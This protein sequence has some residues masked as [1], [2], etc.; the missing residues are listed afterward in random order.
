MTEG[1]PA[2]QRTLALGRRLLVPLSLPWVVM[3]LVVSKPL[4]DAVGERSRDVTVDLGTLWA[5]SM[6]L[7]GVY[8]AFKQR[9]LSWA[10]IFLI[11]SIIG[12]GLGAFVA[13]M[14][15]REHVN[16]IVVEGVRLVAGLVPAAILMGVS[17]SGRS[18]R[19]K[20]LL[21][22]F[23]LGV[24]VH[25]V[26]AVLQYVGYIPTT[27]FQV[28]QPRPSGLYFH[29]VSLGILVNVSLLLVVLA[30]FRGWMRL[31]KAL[32][33]SSVLLAVGVLSTHRAS[34]VVAVIIMFGWLAIRLI[35]EARTLRINLWWV[36][37]VSLVVAVGA[38]GFYAVPS[39]RQYVSTALWNVVDVIG[40]DDLDPSAA[41]FLRGRGQRWAGA[42][43]VIEGGTTAQQVMGHGWQV[44][45]PHSDYIRAVLV[46]GYAGALLLALGLGAIVFGFAAKA[47]RR[48]RLFIGLIVVCTLVYAFTTKPTTYTFY[49]WAATA[50]AWLATKS[51]PSR[52]HLQEGAS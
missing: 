9:T 20:G 34:L 16:Q 30:N 37:G 27:Y 26:V 19:H 31:P 12:L 41:G 2:E 48:G 21:Q 39:G 45:D 4:V 18:F 25:S 14:A 42:F 17:A 1:L 33:L 29:P 36:L 35:L 51:R 11:I 8:W 28:G 6:L 10:Q 49:M 3:A 47:D 5:G 13:A 15:S 52:T 50:L 32:L 23:L 38:T 43:E 7:V 22:V 40:R 24:L 44:V 46:H